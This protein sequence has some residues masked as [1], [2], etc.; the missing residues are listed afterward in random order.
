MGRYIVNGNSGRLNGEITLQGSK[1]AA[2]PIMAASILCGE[3]IVLHNVADISDVR[4]MKEI[5]I[6]IGC[7][8]KSEGNT[9]EIDSS[10]MTGNTVS[11]HLVS[12]M[13]SSIMLLGAMV[14]RCN[15][16]VFSYPG[17]CDIGLRPIDIHLKG[18]KTLGANIR[19]EHGYIIVDGSSMRAEAV[20]L[21]YPS[22]G[23][24]ENLMLASVF[25]RGVTSIHN[26]AKEPEIIDLQNFLNAMGARVYG[27]GTNTIYIEGV[28]KLHS[29]EYSIMPDRIAAVTYLCAAHI[30]GGRVL[31]R[32]ASPE[33]IK[34]PYYK[35]M[36]SG[37]KVKYTSD[38]IWAESSGEISAL[39]SIVT[40]PYPGFPTD[41][42]PLY[43]AML[44]K[45]NGTS[46]INETVFENRYKYTAQLIRMGANIRTEGRVAVIIGTEKLSG[47][48]LSSPDLRGGAAL[49][50]AA[51]G[52]EG[53]SVVSDE[54]HIRRGYEDIEKKLC[55]LGAEVRYI[56]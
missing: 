46:L 44:T 19:E 34:L 27:A 39:D 40:Q 13:R 3:K 45:A 5:L 55:S 35:L 4:L 28:S 30:C 29:C 14:A 8:I 37:L 50:L 16:A 53:Q 56:G 12:Q 17:G 25:T 47:A 6:S 51:L 15:M 23:A 20:H 41:L 33:Y 36:E 7:R 9:V 26:A 38:G 1:N 22:V 43:G 32:G 2:L 10:V 11:E 48:A 24:T 49:L 42:Q 52:A 54:G 21:N 31:I 18:L